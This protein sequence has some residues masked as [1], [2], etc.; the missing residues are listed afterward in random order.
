MVNL[1]QTV[2]DI[3]SDANWTIELNKKLV[4][5]RVQ[6]IKSVKTTNS[7]QTVN[8]NQ[9]FENS[10]SYELI[11]SFG[12]IQFKDPVKNSDS[13]EQIVLLDVNFE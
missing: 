13:F 4:E 10:D 3:D 8:L 12:I 9:S 2:Q 5:Q 1:N 11:A 7:V 6:F